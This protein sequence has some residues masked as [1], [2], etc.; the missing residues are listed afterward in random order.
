MFVV[1]PLFSLALC[2][3]ISMP[4]PGQWSGA[5]VDTL[6][7]DSHQDQSGHQSLAID[8]SGTLHAAWL[9]SLSNGQS[10]VRY[11]MKHSAVPW[12]AGQEVSEPGLTVYEPVL[13][14]ERGTG[15][16]WIAY[17][18]VFGL[19]DE[20]V[21]STDS[22]GTWVHKRITSDGSEDRAPSIAID[23]YNNVH[24]AW[25]G[26]DTLGDWKIKYATNTFG[27]WTTQILHASDLG[28]FG[29]GAAPFLA[30]NV[31]GVAHIV[32]RGGDFATYQ[33]H[34]ATNGSPGGT[35]WTYDFLVTPNAND[36]I[37]QLVVDEVNTLH[38]LASGNEGFGFPPHAYYMKKSEGGNWSA[39][40][41]ANNSG[42]GWGGS[43]FVDRYGKAHVTWNETSGNFY[44]GNL[45]YASNN[46]GT[47]LDQ[48]ILSDGR[49]YN[50]VLVLD[51]SGRGHALAYNGDT[52][53]SQ[54]MV[55]VNSTGTLTGIGDTPPRPEGFRLHQNFPNPF[56][57][58]THIQFEI[59]ESGHVSLKLYD[60]LGQEVAAL[61]DAVLEAGVHRSRL[62][63]SNLSSGVYFYKL[64][65]EGVSETR[66]LILVK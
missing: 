57:P 35:T 50:G 60:L 16:A 21:V 6:T 49:T 24:L 11:A 18:G 66:K 56:N 26:Q 40:V 4:A 43:L 31:N 28:P 27:T 23:G 52:F 30:V 2:C 32:Y 33:I 37:A 3:F 47:W 34:H 55:V 54:E 58:S 12:S 48:A 38:V 53:E 15:K 65:T 59:S 41:L 20:I 5:T 9:T 64:R 17:V 7:H 62:D 13:A 39:P 22:Q 19:S 42:N 1:K 36:F 8:Q 29:S 14:A 61:V 51:E 25:I 10:R 44:T 63:G 46:S 45:F